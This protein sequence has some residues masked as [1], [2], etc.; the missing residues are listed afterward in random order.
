MTRTHLL[1]DHEVARRGPRA[2]L[3]AAGEIQAVGGSGSA[4]AVRSPA[5]R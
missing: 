3:E 1:D 2:L 4:A 5:L